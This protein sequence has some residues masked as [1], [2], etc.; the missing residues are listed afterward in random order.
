VAGLGFGAG[1][2]A[3]A[4]SL[5]P[6][7]PGGAADS[8]V[9]IDPAAWTARPGD[10]PMTVEV[11]NRSS[12]PVAIDRVAIEGMDWIGFVL[13]TK[14]RPRA[15]PA[16]DSIR[17]ELRAD[18]RHFANAP[19]RSGEATLRVLGPQVDAR[20]QLRFAPRGL[21]DGLGR[22]ALGVLGSVAA[23][24]WVSRRRNAAV[25]AFAIGA[26]LALGSLPWT[27]L[28][29]DAL[30]RWVGP[31]ELA[32]CMDG[33]DGGLVRGLALPFDVL[34]WALGMILVAFAS[35]RGAGRAIAVAAPLMA[36]LAVAATGET[37]TPTLLSS[38]G[39]RGFRPFVTLACAAWALAATTRETTP[40][41]RIAWSSL[42]TAVLLSPGW[43]WMTAAMPV[44]L[45]F[46]VLSTGLIVALAAGGARLLGARPPMT[47][48]RLRL[49]ILV[50]IASTVVGIAR[51]WLA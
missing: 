37:I 2:L 44:H 43:G 39:G 25:L 51:A 48:E 40:A 34:W 18:H 10:E 33:R 17:I 42:V 26:A 50:A 19:K 29:P 5:A 45:A 30:T 6:A 1:L 24:W 35:G 9:H 12:A 38:G 22:S 23:G 20:T 14:T 7:S 32:G 3:V 13:E 28:C 15:I 8:K 21:G 47:R 27:V 49:T 36:A 4:Q 16:N 31:R 41:E 46:V 11:H